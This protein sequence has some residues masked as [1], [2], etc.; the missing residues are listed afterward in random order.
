MIAAEIAR[1]CITLMAPTKT[2]NIPGLGCAFAVI[3]DAALRRRFT[4]AMRGIVPD[5]NVLGLTAAEAAYRDCEEWRGALIN[6]LRRNRE[7]VEAAVSVILGL[8]MTC[9]LYTSRC[10]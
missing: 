7:R 5:V 1:R 4:G 3:A 6:A 10:V 2:Y 8:S 9:L